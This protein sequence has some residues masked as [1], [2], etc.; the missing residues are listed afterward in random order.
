MEE[1]RHLELAGVESLQQRNILSG[2]TL[3]KARIR[4]KNEQWSGIN[5]R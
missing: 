5:D 3:H 2:A 4:A 1:R